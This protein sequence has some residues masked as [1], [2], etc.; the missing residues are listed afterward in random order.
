MCLLW[1]PA[2]ML[3]HSDG[4]DPSNISRSISGSFDA[5]ATSAM[6]FDVMAFNHAIESL[7]VHGEH[8]RGSLFVAA[9]VLEHASNIAPFDY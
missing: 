1:L 8:P 7:A 2:L 5:R 3:I 6:T 9:G 4:F